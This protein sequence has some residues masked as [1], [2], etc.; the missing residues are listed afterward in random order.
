MT[1]MP[2]P[3]PPAP[4]P[5]L[6]LPPTPTACQGKTYLCKKVDLDARVAIVRPADVK[7]YTTTSDFVS[8]RGLKGGHLQTACHGA[9]R[10]P[11]KGI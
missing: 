3:P 11:A 10:M 2:L 5:F 7:Y 8:V 6:T 9:R 4:T 1:Q